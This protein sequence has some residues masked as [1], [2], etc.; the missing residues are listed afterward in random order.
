[1]KRLF[2]AFYLLA[3]LLSPQI[4][5]DTSP[6]PLQPV[7][8][9]L[10]WKH[11]FQFAGYYAA[12]EK[13]YYR[14]AG[15]DVRILEAGPTHS[16]VE[17]VV[18][19]G[20]DFGVGTTQLLL[21]R[22]HGAPVVA[23][24]AI[25]Q[26]SPLSLVVR[27]DSGIRTVKDLAGRKLMIG[28]DSAELRAYFK[29]A[30]LDD[31][32]FQ[33]QQH[34]QN[35]IDLINKRTDGLSAYTPNQP[36]I[37][38]QAG[39]DYLEL[40]ALDGGIDFY[41]DVLFTTEQQIKNHPDQVKAFRQASLQGWT[42]A[43]QH[44]DEIAE[45]IHQHYAPDRSL[46]HLL[47]EARR[48]R[49]FIM[50]DLIELGHMSPNRWRHIADTYA[51]LG[52]LPQNFDFSGMLYD[53]NP[54]D[55]R[56]L[57]PW[58]GGGLFLLV[59][60]TLFSGYVAYSRHKLRLAK[61]TL[62]KLLRNAPGMIYQF[63][64]NAD[65]SS[66]LP[67][68]SQGITEVF[69]LDA[70]TVKYDAAAFFALLHPDDLE[71]VRQ[72]IR[73]SAQQ[74]AD[75]TEQFRVIHPKKGGIWV[76]GQATPE[77]LADNTLLWHGFIRDIT[78]RKHAEQ[79]LQNSENRFRQM[80]EH[81]PVAYQSL[82]I[83]GCY[84]DLNKATADMLGY[85]RE[86]LLGRCFGDFWLDPDK[87]Q[88]PVLFKNF[89]T[90]H[91][92]DSE[93]QLR[94]KDGS[95]LTVLI[96]GRIQRGSNGE[97]IRTHCI[98]WD[99][100]ER[101]Q[102]EDMLVEAKITAETANTAKSDFLSHMSHELRTPLNAIIGFAQLLE[103][104]ELAPLSATQ[105]EAIGHI[106]TSS[107]QLL[108]L[109]NETLDLARIESGKLKL[110]IENVELEILTDDVLSLMR[111]VAAARQID[112]AHSCTCHDRVFIRAD[113]LRLR[114]VLQNLLSNAIKYNRPGGSITWSCEVSGDNVRFTIADTGI[115]IS[116]QHRAKIFQSFQRLGAE[117]TAIEG[118][119]IGLVICKQLVEAM[120]GSI[121][122]DSAVGI[123]SQFWF[124][125]PLVVPER[126]IALEAYIDS[127]ENALAASTQAKDRVLY[128]E[129][130]PVNVSVIRHVFRQLPGIELL[131]AENAEIGLALIGKAP[132]NL[133]LMDI[134]LPGINGLEALH[135]LKSNP[136]TAAIPV[137]AVS[138]AARP[139]DVETGLQAGFLAYLVKPFDMRELIELIRKTLPEPSR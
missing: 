124:E 92:V 129:D 77:R 54:Y 12:L 36:Y 31:G 118:T 110:N 3:L 37:L 21:D 105:K 50:A 93:L 65:G 89:K 126:K 32:S 108:S 17:T 67:F 43:M 99:I 40:R 83:E 29:Q 88:F 115:G 109:I 135:I 30:G 48:Y 120:G 8:L 132:P 78:D 2:T 39:V 139:H 41:G 73:D 42:Y 127:R 24:A 68:V 58:L 94:R 1:M 138:A 130:S 56:R 74:M 96:D 18:G 38:E 104:G 59:I 46:E 107:R 112:I 26:H 113:A 95:T 13:G 45:L 137:I 90:T 60:L 114:Q 33:R 128:I 9:Q 66:C 20:A 61:S 125:L 55:L 16:S 10:K 116:D 117:K 52:M 133:V 106:M 81:A 51:N 19:G 15:L 6:L 64:L 70:Q 102:I 47:W 123:G 49:P 69:G 79:T 44:P 87:D 100:S 7:T 57:Y 91:R 28:P 27:R 85:S 71:T 101:K 76:E 22:S 35:I 34:S 131:T 121:G 53:P 82:D 84:L 122:F 80:F 97:F 98:L 4:F 103:M 136:D 11:Q 63:Q 23:L 62:D 14:E 111:P 134:N 119:G 75:W 86:Q 5:A 72:S 25:M